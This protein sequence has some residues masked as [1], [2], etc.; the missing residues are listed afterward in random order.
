MKR[1][2]FLGAI[3]ATPAIT[4]SAPPSPTRRYGHVDYERWVKLGLRDCN[5]RLFVN[6]ND[7]TDRCT[8]FDDVLGFAMCLLPAEHRRPHSYKERIDGRVEVRIP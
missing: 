4:M 6:G 5:A 8:E 1:R 2:A 7:V 3:A